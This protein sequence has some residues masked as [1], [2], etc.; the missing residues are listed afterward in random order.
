MLVAEAGCAVSTENPVA[1]SDKFRKNG[2]APAAP[3]Q[4]RP[5]GEMRT[6]PYNDN[7][8]DFDESYVDR[9]FR[10]FQQLHARK[11]QFEGTGMGLAICRKI[12]ELHGG[13]ITAVSAPGQGA[14]FIVNLPVR[15][16]QGGLA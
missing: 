3:V 12:V 14:T 16:F 4:G 7:D 5:S 15:D 2:E 13:T 11:G 1:D 10:P 8:I 6:V 9:I